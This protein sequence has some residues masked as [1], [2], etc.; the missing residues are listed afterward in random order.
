MESPDHFAGPGQVAI[1][2]ISASLLATYRRKSW[3]LLASER[4]RFWRR[5]VPHGTFVPHSG[6]FARGGGTLDMGKRDEQNLVALG[7]AADPNEFAVFIRYL[8]DDRRSW[9]T[10]YKVLRSTD[11]GQSYLRRARLNCPSLDFEGD[12]DVKELVNTIEATALLDSLIDDPEYKPDMPEAKRWIWRRH[13]RYPPGNNPLYKL[14]VEIAL[15][16]EQR[17]GASADKLK[18]IATVRKLIGAGMGVRALWPS[19]GTR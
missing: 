10:I 16:R 1:D 9:Q 5:G 3:E 11:L 19:G 12:F 4:Q 8:A 6:H 17:Q 18:R 2:Q 7:D 15:L 14:M 13:W